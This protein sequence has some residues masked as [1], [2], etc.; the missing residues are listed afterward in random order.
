MNSCIR[1]LRTVNFRNL[2]PDIIE[3]SPFINCISGENGHGK[4]NILEAVS[5]LINRKSFRKNAGFPQY[6]GMDGEKPVIELISV[7]DWNDK[8]YSYTGVLTANES[9]WSMNSRPVQKNL[10]LRTIF[11]NPFD[12]NSFHLQKDFRRKWFDHHIGLIDSSYRKIL[13]RYNK[14]LVFKNALLKKGSGERQIDVIDRELASN[15]RKITIRRMEFIHSVSS[16]YKDIFRKIFSEEH[17][18]EIFLD[19][20][21]SGK[22]EEEIEK[23]LRENR[24]SDKKI[25]HSGKGS[26][27]DDYLVF[28]DGF[29][30]FEYSSLGQQKTGYLGLLFAYIQLFRYIYNAFPIVLIDDISGELDMVRWERLIEYLKNGRFQVLMTTANEKFQEELKSIYGA[31]RI[32][33]NKGT[34]VQ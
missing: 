27:R 6:L 31:K 2:A 21:F 30:A 24:E 3:F 15:I 7:I 23:I 33:V 12:S 25:G 26:H 9:K 4:T 32:K 18:L 29:N 17:S 19:S 1:K 20:V 11:I 16:H 14:A 22:N 5:L 10:P 28:L 34:I 8:Q 13:G